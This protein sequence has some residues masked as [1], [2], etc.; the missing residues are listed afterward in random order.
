M[1]VVAGGRIKL[2]R[3]SD[4]SLFA[5]AECECGHGK[6]CFKGR[7][8]RAAKKGSRA[9]GRPMGFL[10]AWLRKGLLP[11]TLHAHHHKNGV[12][13]TREDRVEGRKDLEAAV[14]DKAAFV[15]RDAYSDEEDGEPWQEP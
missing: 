7:S 5:N 14:G 4:G 12:A 15:E 10:I 13:V 3:K 2:Y 9:K 6:S 11:T 1:L 8:L